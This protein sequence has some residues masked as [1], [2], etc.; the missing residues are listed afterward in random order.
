MAEIVF[1]GEDIELAVGLA[2]MDGVPM[3]EMDFEILVF[4][5]TRNESIRK[6][7]AECYKIDDNTYSFILQTAKVGVGTIVSVVIARI[8]DGRVDGGYRTAICRIL[9]NITVINPA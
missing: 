1:L 5:R 7:K 8:P 2:P 3:S 4:T 6:E 9:S